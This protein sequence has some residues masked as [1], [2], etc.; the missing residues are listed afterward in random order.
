MNK[1]SYKTRHYVQRKNEH[2]TYHRKLFKTEDK[3]KRSFKE[4]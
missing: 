1:T 3:G 4:Y 2:Q